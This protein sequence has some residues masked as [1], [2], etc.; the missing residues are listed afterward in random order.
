MLNWEGTNLSPP[1]WREEQDQA[2]NIRCYA[3]HFYTVCGNDWPIWLRLAAIFDAVYIPPRCKLRWTAGFA[4]RHQ[5]LHHWSPA[6]N[7]AVAGGFNRT[8][9][10]FYQNSTSILRSSPD[11]EMS[12]LLCAQ[13]FQAATKP[14][15]VLIISICVLWSYISRLRVDDVVIRKTNLTPKKRA[16]NRWRGDKEAN[17]AYS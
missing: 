5:Q 14:Y 13:M 6:R 17:I 4:W 15:H 16:M 7:L 10:L 8:P 2:N 9:E 3:D 11:E 1:A 12:W